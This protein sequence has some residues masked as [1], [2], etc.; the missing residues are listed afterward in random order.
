M[1]KSHYSDSWNPVAIITDPMDLYPLI[2][3]WEGKFRAEHAWDK[4]L[5]E[6]RI[7]NEHF[8][9]TYAYEWGS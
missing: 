6:F 4:P 2:E 9:V 1:Q 7:G 5:N 3:D 8:K